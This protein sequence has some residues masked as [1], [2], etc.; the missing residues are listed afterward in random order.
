MK[1]H[2]F[3]PPLL[4]CLFVLFPLAVQAQQLTGYEYWFDGDIGNSVFKSLSG[5]EAEIN[6]NIPTQHLSDGL[7]TLSLHVKQSDG[8]YSAVTSSVFFKHNAS[9][10]NKMEY[11]FDDK[12]DNPTTIDLPSSATEELTEFSLNLQDNTEFPVGLHKLHMRV[13]TEGKS[14]GAIYT[15]NV[16]K[17]TSGEADIVEY[18]VDG[19]FAN[20]KT[21]SGHLSAS[22]GHDYV[23]VDPFDLQGIPAGLHRI[24]YRA[25]SANGL[26]NSAVNMATV[27]VRAGTTSYLEYWIDDDRT[28]IKTL[29]GK[30]SSDHDGYIF[31]NDLNLDNVSPGHHRLYCRAVSSSGKTASAV[32]MTPIIVKSRYNVAPEDV[33]MSSFSIAVDNEEPII[34]K[35]KESSDELILNPYTLDVRDLAVG[36]HTLKAHFWNSVNAGVAFEQTF[37]VNA[38]ET[39]KIELIAT[40]KDGF[41]T[42]SFNSIPNDVSWGIF[43]TDANGA[44]AKVAGKSQSIYPSNATV[45]DHPP[46][47]SY[48]YMVRGVYTDADGTKHAVNSNEVTMTVTESPDVAF[49]KISGSIRKGIDNSPLWGIKWDV[50]FS[51]GFETQSDEYGNYYRDNIPVGTE[52]E[53]N[54]KTQDYY[55]EKQSITVMEGENMLYHTALFNEEEY[56]SHFTHD[57]QF[58]SNVEFAPRLNMKFKVKNITRYSWEGKLRIVTARKDYVDNPPKNP[59]ESTDA[60]V[61]AGSVASFVVNDYYQYDYSVRIYLSPGESKEV[62]IRH[63]V[64]ITTP[65]TG[66]DELY[67]FYVESVDEYGS[68]LIATN[69]DYN[70]K[71]NPLVQLVDN[72]DYSSGEED[73]EMCVNIIMAL[74]STLPEL[75]GKL[76]DMSKCMDEMQETLGYALD[77]DDLAGKIERS[78]SYSYI[79]DAIPEWK[80]YNILYNED[81][82]FLGMVNAVRDEISD[83]VRLSKDAL[84]Y[85][86]K[87]KACLDAVKSY[88]Q[89][90]DMTDLERA[91]A[92]AD[93]ILDLSEDAFPF[94]K[95]LKTYLDVTKNT[96]HN[97]IGLGKKWDD[98][99]AYMTFRDDE[100]V[101]DIIVKKKGWISKT[102]DAEAVK[103][104]I[105]SVEVTAIGETYT[106]DE[107]NCISTYTPIVQDGKIRLKR[108]SAIGPQ[109]EKGAVIP[110]KDMWMKIW[111]SNGRVS[112]VPI[113]NSS[114]MT[115]NGVKYE[116]NHYTIT[117]QSKSKKEEYMADIINLDD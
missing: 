79:R 30:E 27:I 64:P 86:K 88:N 41:V 67:Y 37:K 46:V 6:T 17:I 73:L 23:F 95:I 97:I 93:K 69:D 49:G 56:R 104:R 24:Y 113:R 2:R 4:S 106:A 22:G 10:G 26:T 82:R 103:E 112:Y 11:W 75:D 109:P 65:P 50:T 3:I 83:A 76:G 29:T 43:R 34:V 80:F 101:F 70:I 105:L 32:T 96:I 51:D 117:F 13:S 98:N 8:K 71:E 20:R 47:G 48:T 87:V 114:E 107:A 5:Y 14:L 102:F 58:D 21:V 94:A 66:K 100:I 31:I 62:V 15:S 91:G 7:H 59:F 9:E 12:Y 25:T 16:L 111:W 77:Y 1:H 44:K 36:N 89:W 63:N 57:L 92:V 99:H 54:I 39:P 84:K 81:R 78:G 85:T 68:K 108:V 52:L 61:L 40:E 45:L 53:I 35:T 90:Q 33:K 55:C 72:G 116:R 115:G 19:D 28:N 110:I 74:C 18:W 38:V 60:Q 42:L